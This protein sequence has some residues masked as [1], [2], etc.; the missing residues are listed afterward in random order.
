ME[1]GSRHFCTYLAMSILHSTR[2]T[3]FI[4]QSVL[5]TWVHTRVYPNYLYRHSAFLGPFPLSRPDRLDTY[6]GAPD[7]F[8]TNRISLLVL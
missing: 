1:V 5:F 3:K 4:V 8:L 2:F 6:A 7:L